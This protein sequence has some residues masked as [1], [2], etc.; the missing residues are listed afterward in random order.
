MTGS[1]QMP[2]SIGG[3]NTNS[4]GTIN[5][6]TCQWNGANNNDVWI[7]YTATASNTCLSI[8]GISGVN[9]ALQSIV[10]TDSNPNDSD[11]CTMLPK[12][13]T[14]D[15]NWTVVSCP[16]PSIYGT[17]AGTQFNQQHCFASEIG[18]TYYLVIDGDGG[19][20]SKFWIWGFSYNG[21]LEL[22]ETKYTNTIR[23]NFSIDNANGILI[24]KNARPHK[25]NIFIYDL[26]GRV[27]YKNEVFVRKENKLDLNPY[28]KPG[29]NL[30]RVVVDDNLE[31]HTFKYLK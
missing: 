22:V 25:Q 27:F 8:S 17:T 18:K 6:V 13:A 4:F 11:P 31:T 30:I 2:G 15:P 28:L 24:T 19:S 16:R 5:N 26:S 29:I 7:K 9:L 12:T 3:P 23:N 20:Q 10:V 1:T 21:I 14:N